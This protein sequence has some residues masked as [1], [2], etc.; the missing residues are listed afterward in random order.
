MKSTTEGWPKSGTSVRRHVRGIERGWIANGR[1]RGRGS[2]IDPWIV[3]TVDVHWTAAVT[4]EDAVQWIE[5]GGT[6]PEIASVVEAAA[7]T[8]AG[9]TEMIEVAETDEI[10]EDVANPRTTSTRTR[11][12]R[13]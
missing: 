8:V 3:T 10:A 9:T 13:A 2:V 4:E 7:G 5:A 6:A 12:A 1:G 11:S